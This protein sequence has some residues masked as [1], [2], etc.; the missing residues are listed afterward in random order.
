MDE[1][2]ATQAYKHRST[3]HHIEGLDKTMSPFVLSYPTIV[4]VLLLLVAL[5]FCDEDDDR[6]RCR[7]MANVIAKWTVGI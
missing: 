7:L 4:L 6:S 5:L 3:L 2:K 1:Y